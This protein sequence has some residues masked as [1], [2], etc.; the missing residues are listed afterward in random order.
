MSSLELR[1][2][3]RRGTYTF[4]WNSLTWVGQVLD[5]NRKYGLKVGIPIPQ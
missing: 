5:C 2:L 4:P 1:F 3:A